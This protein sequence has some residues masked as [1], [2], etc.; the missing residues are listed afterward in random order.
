MTKIIPRINKSLK[1]ILSNFTY[2]SKPDFIAITAQ[3]ADPSELFDVLNKHTLVKGSNVNEVYL[4]KSISNYHS[5]FALP[6]IL[7]VGRKVFDVLS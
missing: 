7:K 6:H 2:D 3:K 4:N 5:S 1:V